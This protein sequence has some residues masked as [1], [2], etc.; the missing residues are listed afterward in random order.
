DEGTGG[1]SGI[2]YALIHEVSSV[3]DF[4]ELTN[5]HSI[6]ADIARSRGKGS[7]V[8]IAKTEQDKGSDTETPDEIDSE[9]TGS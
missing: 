9:E 8:Q 6:A 7:D 4:D 5:P 2:S 1:S 3:T